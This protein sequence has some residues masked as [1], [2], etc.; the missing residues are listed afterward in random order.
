MQSFS[1][2]LKQILKTENL[3]PYGASLIIGAETDEPIKTI[4][5]RLNRWLI[6][7]PKTWKDIESSLSYLGYEIVIQKRK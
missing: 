6:R 1:S 4:D 3:T 2:K 5:Q 7:T